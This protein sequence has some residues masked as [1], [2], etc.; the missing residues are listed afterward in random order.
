MPPFDCK[1]AII[2][3]ILFTANK[4]PIRERLYGWI[5]MALF[6]S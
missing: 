2:A 3:I 1:I 5:Q 6:W 4:A